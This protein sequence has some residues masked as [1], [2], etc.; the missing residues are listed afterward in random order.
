M[1]NLKKG[2]MEHPKNFSI[3]IKKEIPRSVIEA[4]FVT[5]LEGGS[6]YWYFLPDDAVGIIRKAV[7][8]DQDK[9]L[10][11]A[12]AK[13]VLDHGAKVPINDAEDEEELLGYISASTMQERLQ[14][15]A[16]DDDY[17]WALDRELKEDGDAESSDVVFQY[18]AFG[19]VLF[20]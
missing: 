11:T 5:A 16:E 8:K 1:I 4:V 3:V 19:E 14:K 13:A 10:S 6:N 2:N 9:Y 18:L 7:P 20:S 12:F 17:N 15:L